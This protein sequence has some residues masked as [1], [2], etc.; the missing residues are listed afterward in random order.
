MLAFHRNWAYVV[1]AL[2]LAAGL[3]GLFTGIRKREAPR[4]LW[5]AIVAGQVA[6]GVQVVVGVVLYQSRKPPGL[7]LFYG[8]VVLIAAVLS[9]AFRSYSPRQTLLI[10]SGIA[11]FIGAVSVRAVITA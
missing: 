1:I 3:W 4:P 5:P 8:F 2:N 7:H 6:L 9:Y 11:V 10:S